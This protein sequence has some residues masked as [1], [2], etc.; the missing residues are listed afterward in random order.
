M[1]DAPGGLT[2]ASFQ[3]TCLEVGDWIWG[4][5]QGAFNEKAT[6]SQII[7][8]AVIGMIP[9]VGDVTGVRDLLAVVIGLSMDPRKRE[10][11]AQWIMLVVLAL[12]LIPVVGG[13]IKGVGRLLIKA[14]GEAAQLAGQAQKAAHL[15]QAAKDI[16]RTSRLG[17]P[18]VAS[19]KTNR[20]SHGLP[21]THGARAPS[22]V[23]L[24]RASRV[25]HGLA[26]ALF[27]PP[28]LRGCR[29]QRVRGG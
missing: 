25:A 21:I 7:V 24:A 15:A 14:I 12:A 26:P 3:S 20:R 29:A 23:R 19:K 1:S 9:V 28:A 18:V 8:D 10:D 27:I 6:M 13:V 11:K 17:E 16:V 2:L 22:A 5:A 4:T